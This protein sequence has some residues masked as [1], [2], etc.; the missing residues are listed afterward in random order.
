[1]ATYARL[2]E[3]ARAHGN[4]AAATAEGAAVEVV[5]ICQDGSAIVETMVVRTLA[6]L[7]AVLGY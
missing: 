3:V 1:M 2:A 6:E 7:L 5:W 4:A